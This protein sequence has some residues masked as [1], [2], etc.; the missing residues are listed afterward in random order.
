M[1][2]VQF[3]T[4][5]YHP[6][7]PYLRTELQTIQVSPRNFQ[8]ISTSSLTVHPIPGSPV[9]PAGVNRTP[10]IPTDVRDHGCGLQ[11]NT[12]LSSSSDISETWDQVCCDQPL[13]NMVL[14]SQDISQETTGK[15]EHTAG[16]SD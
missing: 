13:P 10:S 16:A 11:S 9:S 4:Q 8:L 1:T 5:F 14:G 7:L 3:Q 2:V 12:P 6:H 15:Y